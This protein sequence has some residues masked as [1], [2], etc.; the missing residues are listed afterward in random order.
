MAS[1]PSPILQN[2]GRSR[3]VVDI[4]SNGIRLLIGAVS[5]SGQ[6]KRLVKQRVPIRLGKDVFQNQAISRASIEQTTEAFLRFNREFSKHSVEKVRVVATSAVR[7]AQ[8]QIQFVSHL[9]EKTGLQVEVIDFK[10]EARLILNAVI[11]VLP[12]KDRPFLLM[13]IGGGSVELILADRGKLKSVISLPLGTVRMLRGTSSSKALSDEMTAQIGKHSKKIRDLI[14]SSRSPIRYFIGT[15][16]N[17]ECLGD[18]RKTLLKKESRTKIRAH[19]LD[20]IVEELFLL[21]TEDRIHRLNLRPDRADVI[22]PASLLT[23]N[24]LARLQ[25]NQ[26]VLPGVGLREGVLLHLK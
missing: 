16:G 21:S 17:M 18:L 23:Q 8:N 15:G 11:S 19:E 22:L 24:V 6:I 10:E 13:D 25:L 4:G 12:V 3:G 26:V 20:Y 9:R 2:Y 7:E 14:G 1:F 5:D